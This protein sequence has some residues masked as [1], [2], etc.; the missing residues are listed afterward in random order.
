MF[1]TDESGILDG[2]LQDIVHVLLDENYAYQEA[3]VRQE[4]GKRR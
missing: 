3:T 1:F 4:N 2:F